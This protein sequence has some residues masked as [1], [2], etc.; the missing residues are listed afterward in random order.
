[1]PH[2]FPLIASYN[3]LV[4]LMEGKTMSLAISV[5]TLRMGVCTGTTFTDSTQMHNKLHLERAI[6]NCGLFIFPQRP[7][8]KYVVEQTSRL[9]LF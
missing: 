1:M 6:R 5:K 9:S 2:P 8:I 3:R 7:S 4:E